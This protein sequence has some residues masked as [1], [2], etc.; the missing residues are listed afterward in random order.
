MDFRYLAQSLQLDD[1]QLA[2][3]SSFLQLFHT[4][5]QSI[6]DARARVGKGNKP[7]THFQIP[8]L[9]LLHAVVPSVTASRVTMQWT[10]DT[11]EH[12]HI[13]E[14]KVPR[15]SGNNQSYSPQ[16]C[17]W[18]DHS[19]KHRNFALALFIYEIQ[20]HPYDTDPP[21]HHD[22]NPNDPD[23]DADNDGQSTAHSDPSQPDLFSRA[24]LLS[25][26]INPSTPLPLRTMYTDT[27]A[28][29]LNFHPNLPPITVDEAT[30]KFKLP[31]LQ[32]AIADYVRCLWDLQ[33][34]T[35]KIGQRRM[36]PPD[37][38]LP[39]THLRV[40]YSVQM[41]MCSSDVAGLTDPQWV[42]AMPAT[43]NWP[44]GRYDTVLLSNGMT[45]GP[46]L[47]GKYF[48]LPS[49]LLSADKF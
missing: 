5:K 41:Q 10:A 39:F 6:L 46:G 15:R 19:E 21:E 2:Q 7:M 35:T 34:S 3:I 26:N 24:A 28:F 36:S 14:I 18:L 11:M 1:N 30:I 49:P 12:A 37:A 25:A 17:R 42:S 38:T 47:E 31:D 13:T 20:L 27:T 16:I 22:N 23:S 44:F 48:I 32:P 43:D 8:K 33:S 9:E 4:H 29:Q 40:W 45:P